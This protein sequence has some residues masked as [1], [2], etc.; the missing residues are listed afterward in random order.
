MASIEDRWHRKT[1]G[2]R[3]A[4]YGKG[5]R[6]R[7]RWYGPDGE[8]DN[9]SFDKWADANAK[10]I[11]IEGDLLRGTY[12]SP[13]AGKV[14]FD[15]YAAEWLADRRSD[16]LTIQNTRDR[17]RRY[18]TGTRLGKSQIAKIRPSTVQAW[19]KGMTVGES[20]KRVVFDHVSSIFSAAIDDGLIGSNP[21]QSKSVTVPKRTREKVIPWTHKMVADMRTNIAERYRPLITLGAGLGLRAG[22]V[23]GLSPDDVDWLRGKVTI[24]RQVKIVGNRRCFA[25]PK[26][27]KVRTVP[28][29]AIL[30][31]ELAAYLATY[32]PK[33]ITLPWKQPGGE[34]TTVPLMVTNERGDALHSSTVNNTVLPRALEASGIDNT[35]ENKSHALRHYYASVTLANGGDIRALSEYLGHG[36]PAF[37]L[38]IYAHMMPQ[39]EDRF[40]SAIDAAF[41]EIAKASEAGAA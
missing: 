13:K 26:G 6:W 1:D 37:T 12:V 17:L 10:R 21:C 38:R 34:A 4:R 3:T 8:P 36:D 15:S 5:Q 14:T 39:A 30:R 23:A 35:R 28:L 22:E 40:R 18:V 2:G 32:P 20:T 16:P 24:R 31:D 9:L 7:V 27:G 19:L 25:P 41:A 29:S 11:E 33:E